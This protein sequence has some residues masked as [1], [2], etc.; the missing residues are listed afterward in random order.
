MVSTSTFRGCR[1]QEL[2]LQLGMSL[3]IW[4]GHSVQEQVLFKNWGAIFVASFLDFFF[5]LNVCSGLE[6]QISRLT[7]QPPYYLSHLPSSNTPSRTFYL[8][9]QWVVFIEPQ[10]IHGFSVFPITASDSLAALLIFLK[11]QILY[12]LIFWFFHFWFFSLLS[13]LLW[14]Q[15]LFFLT[16]KIDAYPAF[17]VL[18]HARLAAGVFSS[19]CTLAVTIYY[20]YRYR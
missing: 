17:T 8:C 13:H 1:H 6:P 9:F 12:L 5:L 3:V 10:L 19:N 7:C 14:I 18:H 2:E 16:L 20:M 11:N 4:V 15:N